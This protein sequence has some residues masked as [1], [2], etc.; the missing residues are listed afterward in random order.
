M[1]KAVSFSTYLVIVVTVFVAM[2]VVTVVVFF[3]VERAAHHVPG[4]RP[5]LKIEEPA[6][7]AAPS[8]DAAKDS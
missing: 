7:P 2:V 8:G 4:A 5:D 6:A 1:A 3:A